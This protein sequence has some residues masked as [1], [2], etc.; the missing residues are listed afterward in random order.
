MEHD[1]NIADLLSDRKRESLER[2]WARAKAA[3]ESGPLPAGEYVAAIVSSKLATASTGTE[4][5]KLT[6]EVLEGEQAG[7]R[8]WHDLWLTEAAMP[9]TKRDLAKLGV[10]EFDQLDTPL[11]RGIRCRVKVAL[12]RDDNGVA[13]NRVQA[14]EV[15][16]FK[17]P[18]ADPFAPVGPTRP[19]AGKPTT[20]VSVPTQQ[21][22]LDLLAEFAYRQE[23]TA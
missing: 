17:T 13:W 10:T 3:N 2:A 15:V 12:R 6:F 9:M 23:V 11:P 4:S 8:L 20:A 22:E 1:V 19:P 5:L 16:G 7:C 18:E 21:T 14:F